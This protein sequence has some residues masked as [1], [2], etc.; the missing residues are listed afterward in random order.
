MWNRETQRAHTLAPL[1][2]SP[3]SLSFPP[4]L[5]LMPLSL[6]SPRFAVRHTFFAQFVGGDTALDC[7]P[8]VRKLR[9]ENIGT[10]FNYSVE[11]SEE[12]L[13]RSASSSGGGEKELYAARRKNAAATVEETIRAIVVSG[14]ENQRYFDEVPKKLEDGEMGSTW[15]AVKLVSQKK[16]GRES[17]PGRHGRADFVFVFVSALG[18]SGLISDPTI[19]HRASNTILAIREQHSS[20]SNQVYYP[21]VSLDSLVRSTRLDLHSN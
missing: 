8:V 5:P 14:A 19:L 13:L 9:K 15:V 11:V 12:D 4:L 7:L 1:P 10:L 16:T 18:Q 20:A 6:R 3:S 17:K 21:G 2:P